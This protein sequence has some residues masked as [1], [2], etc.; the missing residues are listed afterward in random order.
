MHVEPNRGN[1]LKSNVCKRGYL[2]FTWAAFFVL[3]ALFISFITSRVHYNLLLP[4]LAQALAIVANLDNFK[5][6]AIFLSILL[7]NLAI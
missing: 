1:W 3:P 6:V 7:Q 5:S 2:K 4:E